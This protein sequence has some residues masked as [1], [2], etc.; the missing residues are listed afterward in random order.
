M[1]RLLY[2]AMHSPDGKLPDACDIAGPGGMPVA[3]VGAAGCLAAVSDWDP[4]WISNTQALLGYGHVIESLWKRTTVIPMRFGNVFEG[5]NGVKELLEKRCAR[6]EE[7]AGE[8]L[9]TA[10]MGLKLIGP[11]DGGTPVAAGVIPAA[12]IPPAGAATGKSYLA[13]R[14]ELF[15][16][17]E[18]GSLEQKLQMD[19]M[20]K[21]FAGLF[22]K[23]HRECRADCASMDFLVEKEMVGAFIGRYRGIGDAGTLRLLVSGPW[24]PYSFAGM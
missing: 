15:R 13:S 18:L 2:C 23:L 16:I 4:S 1:K 24:P 6:I 17:Q 12:N 22:I 9:G 21:L 19:T 7:L 10:E 20:E 14:K 3:F 8:L 5:D 11:A